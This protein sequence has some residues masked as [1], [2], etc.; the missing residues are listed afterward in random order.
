MVLVALV[1]PAVVLA[2]VTVSGAIFA[3]GAI[4]VPVKAAV[5]GFSAS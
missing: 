5:A 3:V 4:P 1:R 2:K